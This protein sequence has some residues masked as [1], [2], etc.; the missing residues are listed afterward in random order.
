MAQDNPLSNR[1][2][3][4][5]KLLQEG[6]SNKLIASALH[7]TESTVE[8]HLKNIYT[9]YQVGSRMELLIKLR[10]STVAN[11]GGDVDNGDRLIRKWAASLRDAVSKIYKESKVENLLVSNDRSGAGSMTFFESIQVCFKK[12]ADFTGRAS[13]AEFW[14]FTLFVTLVTSALA[15]M[16]QTLASVFLIA[17]L[18]PLLAVGARRL[19][20]CGRSLWW[21]LFLLAPIG[22]LVLVG[23]LCAEKPVADETHTV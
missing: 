7:I 4:V 17:V 8:F 10:E 3:E 11:Q 22:G 12:Y 5:V 21:L 9:K 1:E 13:R 20:D 18:L 23:F 16:S 14:W 2:W 15:Y 19:R 6:K